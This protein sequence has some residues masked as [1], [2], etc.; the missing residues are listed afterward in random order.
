MLDISPLA[1]DCKPASHDRSESG[2]V[3]ELPNGLD[4]VRH[5][6]ICEHFFG[7]RLVGAITAAEIIQ[8]LAFRR[9]VQRLHA[10]GP[11][12][13]AELLSEIGAERSL[14]SLIKAKIEKYVDIDDAPALDATGG[15]D[16]P[17]DPLH[18][19]DDVGAAG[20]ADDG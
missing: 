2:D 15:R 5:R 10:K 8:D 19:V 6:I 18:E 11:R 16:F 9:K 17:P 20:E 4:P 13:V 3:A 14:T 12:L 7:F 1:T